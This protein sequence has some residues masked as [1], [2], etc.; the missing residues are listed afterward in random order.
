VSSVAGLRKR[1]VV[2]HI[3]LGM[4]EQ[5]P[6]HLDTSN[7]TGPVKRSPVVDIHPAICEQEPHHVKVP[8]ARCSRKGAIQVDIDPSLSEQ[9][10]HRRKVTPLTRILQGLPLQTQPTE[11]AIHVLGVHR[12]GG[13][14]RTKGTDKENGRQARLRGSICPLSLY[15]FEL[16]EAVAVKD[17]K[18]KEGSCVLM[19]PPGDQFLGKVYKSFL[20]AGGYHRIP[21]SK[22]PS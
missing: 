14:G 9:Q 20:L 7:T 17:D 2:V 22:P 12:E 4:S 15:F 8:P 21:Y 16:D 5:E 18:G 10:P 19:L 6:G 3:N 1:S 13:A 11:K